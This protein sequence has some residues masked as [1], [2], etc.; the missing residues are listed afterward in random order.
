[1]I[2]ER[3]G[4]ASIAFYRGQLLDWNTFK[5]HVDQVRR[6]ILR[7]DSSQVKRSDK[8]L[9]L[10][11]D[12]YHFLVVFTASMLEGYMTIMPANRSEGELQRIS[13][14]HK[15]VR[16]VHDDQVA[17]VMS[18]ESLNA[19][20]HTE[21]SMSDIP[22]ELVV[23]ELY[24]S[25]STGVPDANSK[26]WGQ[27]IDGVGRVAKEFKL[28]TMSRSSMIATI[29][30]QHMFGFEMSIVMPLLCGVVIH[31]GQPFY[32]LDIQAAL[33]SVPA[34][35]VLI[36]TP[37]HLKACNTL[38]DGWAE[39][40]LIVSATAPMPED[41]AR[42]AE[43]L[44]NTEVKEI[45]GCSEAG[46]IA[47]RRTT[48]SSHW[49][50]LPDYELTVDDDKT[51]L[52]TPAKHEPTL[53]PDK[54]KMR[55]DRSFMLLGRSSDLIKIAGK[56]GSLVDIA[57]HIKSVPGV[58]DAVVFMP[59]CGDDTPGRL[60]ALVV[61]PGLTA[62]HLR[63]ALVRDIDPVFIPRPLCLL[64][65]LPY[66]PTGKLTRMSLMQSLDKYKHEH[67]AC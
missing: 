59:E 33:A 17:A 20:S 62:E 36:T 41:V 9:N 6:G 2:E 5:H 4:T 49:D 22:E 60:A 58:E 46:A 32:P 54:L 1:M 25:G 31:H 28:D 61:A 63:G 37:I 18:H 47:T 30:P 66:S 7:V 65:A 67:Q 53:I 38:M 11:E 42:Q 8:V 56:R 55:H 44:L 48:Q 19:N 3:E 40:V 51:L 27:L 64:S 15:G 16:L 13:D 39:I 45:Y 12:R 50:L 23:A 26:T 34:P 29:P 10:C 52:Q 21:W 24:T 14:S 35:A 57:A 43:V